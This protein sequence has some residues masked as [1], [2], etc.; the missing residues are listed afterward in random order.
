MSEVTH[1]LADCGE[2]E[3]G[4]IMDYSDEGEAMYDAYSVEV[5]LSH[6]GIEDYAGNTPFVSP[7]EAT[8]QNCIDI[9]A[10]E[11]LKGLNDE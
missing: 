9:Y 5:E 1:I 10:L 4:Y 11:L 6:C 3:E 8:C 7:T 2:Y